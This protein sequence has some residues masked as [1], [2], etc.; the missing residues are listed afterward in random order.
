MTDVIPSVQ[1]G[2]D[3]NF[4]DDPSF[5]DMQS[6]SPGKEKPAVVRN[7][8]RL[9]MMG[10]SESWTQLISWKTLKAIFIKR[11]SELMREFRLAFQQGF[12]S[13]FAQLQ[14]KT[15]NPQQVEQVQLYL[16]NCLSL[17]PYSDI[18]PYEF[19]RIP[20]YINDEWVLVDYYVNPIELTS[21]ADNQITDEDRVFAYGLEPLDHEDAP[22]HL[23]FMGTTY[24]AG[25]GFVT[26]V[27]SD[28][29]AFET[30]GRSLY[31]SGQH[32][33]YDW[34]DRQKP[35]VHVCGVSLGGS[36]SLLFAMS[37][38]HLFSRVDAL[39]PAGL[40]NLK[41]NKKYDCWEAL[42]NKPRVV[43]QQQGNDPV[44]FLG[45][46][47]PD[48]ELV[49]VQPPKDKAGPNPFYDHFMNY[50]GF[51]QTQ[52]SPR[53]ATYENSQRKLEHVLLY[54]FG[55]AFIYYFAIVPYNMVLKPLKNLIIANK[56]QYIST[57]LALACACL[58]IGLVV[59]GFISTLVFTLA[60]V[61]VVLAL[62][63][64]LLIDAFYP[65]LFSSEA[66]LPQSADYAHL[67]D[68]A[69]S[70]NAAM[71]LYHIE[72]ETEITL[73]HQQLSDYYK[74]MRCLLKHKEY[75]PQDESKCLKGTHFSKKEVLSRI[76]DEGDITLKTSKAKAV[77]MQHVLTFIQRIGFENEKKLKE[78][79]TKDYYQYRIG[80]NK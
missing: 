33:V 54:G 35:G 32:N 24:P 17:L 76:Q 26:Q 70:R 41:D 67:H 42:Q 43:I 77:H 55:R 10:Y 52:F 25:Q 80:K 60:L 3:L 6:L 29:Q 23:I 11:D 31:L 79:L 47:K 45:V 19:F 16:S 38:G 59:L 39:N 50:A 20:Q 57:G 28:M 69:L 73:S 18:T 48:W 64:T 68:P 63:S 12:Y 44:S 37:M 74:A 2:L 1:G 75:V 22:S 40:Y 8:L 30:V 36:L 61:G 78:T 72:N 15:L 21:K 62:G 56:V 13:I 7:A 4:F 5:E 58:L 27:T 46:W 14:G 71:D 51:A 34:L 53:D 66:I 49:W 9:L 65:Q